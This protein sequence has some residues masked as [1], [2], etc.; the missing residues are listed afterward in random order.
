MEEIK[1][2]DFTK[3][4]DEN[5]GKRKFRQS[6]ELAIN[7]KGI[8]FNKQDNKLNL[9][10]NLPH[11]KG[12]VKKLGIF[13]TEKSLIEN[14]EKLG[15]EIFD[16][17]RLDSIA[18]DSARMNS[19]LNYD[20]IAQQSL[21][22]SIAKFLGQFLGPRNRMPKPLIGNMTLAAI[23]N[24]M[25]K[26]IAIKTKGK[27]LPTVHCIVG[28]EDIEPKKLYENMNEVISTVVKKVGQGRIR[29]A[30]LKLSMSKPIKVM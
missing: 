19:L 17:A 6:V 20:L 28:S 10:V 4:I 15:I 5:K 1:L 2:E 25:T 8:D 29:S 7:F 9:E 12:K 30:Y 18:G 14:A 21:M 27:N 16:G 3:F 26:R 13:A 23:S 22:P 11:G 24:E